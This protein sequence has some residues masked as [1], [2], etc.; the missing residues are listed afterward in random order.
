MALFWKKWNVPIITEEDA[1]KKVKILQVHMKFL[2]IISPAPK[3]T[4]LP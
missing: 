3:V 1:N 2:I 4:K